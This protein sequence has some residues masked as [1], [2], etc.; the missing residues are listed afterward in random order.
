MGG[1]RCVQPH[2]FP[3]QQV[4][5]HR[6]SQQR[7]AEPVAPVVGDDQQVVV[8]DLGQGLL[9]LATG[10]PAHGRHQLVPDPAAGDC[11]DAQHLLRRR[12]ALL[13]AGEQDVGESE[14]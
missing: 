4:G 8:H 5:Q 7:V 12:R 1:D 6:L 9:Q 3:R 10:E 13:D 2:A 14:R 11:C